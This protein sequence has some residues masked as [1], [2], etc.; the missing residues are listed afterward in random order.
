MV[1]QVAEAIGRAI[2]ALV[3]DEVAEV[4]V[5]LSDEDIARVL[6]GEIVPLSGLDYPDEEARARAV[7]FFRDKKGYPR[8]G[9]KRGECLDCKAMVPG[10]APWETFM[11]LCPSC[12]AKR[13]IEKALEKAPTVPKRKVYGRRR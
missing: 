7:A 5:G 9:W 8:R 13:R 10:E 4:E 3:A 2:L 12:R 11:W 1:P 6:D